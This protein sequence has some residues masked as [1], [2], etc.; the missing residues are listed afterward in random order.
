MLMRLIGAYAELVYTIGFGTPREVTRDMLGHL[1]GNPHFTP[2]RPLTRN[3]IWYG[4]PTASMW[5]DYDRLINDPEN[6]WFK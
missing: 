4:V 1:G 5:R 6:G 3:P 2:P